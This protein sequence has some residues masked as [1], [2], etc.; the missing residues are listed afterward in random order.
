MSRVLRIIIVIVYSSVFLWGQGP[1]NYLPQELLI[2]W[3]T[4]SSSSQKSNLRNT[5]RA[6]QSKYFKSLDIEVWEVAT[7]DSKELESIIKE[8]QDHPAIE[9]IE[10]NYIYSISEVLPNDPKFEEQWGLKNIGQ[11]EGMIGADLQITNGWYINRE[12]PSVKVAII[13]SGID[14]KH[15][16]LVDNIWQNL[17]EDADGDGRVIEWNGSE[18]VFD[19]DDENFIDDDGNGY[20]DDFVG[21]DFAN[22]DNDPFDDNFHGTHVAGTIGAKGNNEIGIAGVTWEVQMA[23]LKFLNAN[24]FG[25]TTKAIEAI[26]YAVQMGM[27][28]SNNSWGGP[29]YSAALNLA[30]QNAGFQNHLLIA[31]A[32]NNGSNADINPTYPAAYPLENIISVASIDYS[33]QLSGFSNYGAISVDVAAPG[34]RIIST[35][36]NNS[37][38]TISGTSMAAPHVTGACALLKEL[39][40][41][42]SYQTIKSEVLNAVD[43][44]STEDISVTN[45]R[46]NI[47]KLLGGCDHETVSCAYRDSLALVALYHATN[48]ANWNR[49]SESVAW[50]LSQPMSTWTGVL[51]SAEGC[52]EELHLFDRDLIGTLPPE[53]GTLFNLEVLNLHGNQLT[54]TIPEEMWDLYSSLSLSNNQLTGT[55]PNKID[56]L[57]NLIQL[58]LSN[59]QLEGE[60]PDGIG[61]LKELIILD[62]SHNQLSGP[63]P[64]W[65]SGL[66]DIQTLNLSNNNFTGNIPYTIGNLASNIDLLTVDFGN[67]QLEGCFPPSLLEL[68]LL[69]VYVNFYD[70]EELPLNG[71]HVI[72]FCAY[73]SENGPSTCP[74]NRQIDSLILVDLYNSAGGESWGAI[75][76]LDQPMDYWIGVTLWNNCVTGLELPHDALTG[77]IP[78]SLST[79]MKIWMGKAGFSLGTYNHL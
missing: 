20:I 16:D 71:D 57:L 68:C 8:Y 75:W 30:I 40:P 52:V 64:E 28:F 77:P 79:S 43:V 2:K 61:N 63:I 29:F 72:S 47:C 42:K 74:C 32:G 14:W 35:F 1:P 55:I 37:Y 31:A 26:D 24:G 33:N 9:F 70:N 17:G 51:T 60:L 59:N 48:G 69:P 38:G 11:H 4:T 66:E 5:L 56:R 78:A 58:E 36:P 25:S 39:Q 3:N 45:G 10:P 15:P 21:W 13:D 7:E 19:P 54:G 6:T 18:W 65:V 46:L 49:N 67:N 73:E 12:S 53:I 34:S 62:L 22:N 50:D 41:N 44:F 23:A 27:D 76:N